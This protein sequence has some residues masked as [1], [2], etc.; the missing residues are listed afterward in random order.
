MP[1]WQFDLQQFNSNVSQ[2]PTP[3]ADELQGGYLEKAYQP[4]LVPN[5]TY[6]LACDNLEVP[7]HTGDSITR[8]K[9][10]L[11]TANEDPIDPSTATGIDNG[12]TD[13][14][15]NNEQYTVTME[16]FNGTQSI[17]IK[18][19]PMGIVDRFR[20]VVKASVKQSRQSVD[21]YR[22]NMLMGGLVVSKGTL[23]L[24]DGYAGGTTIVT[25][26][27]TTST[28]AHVDDC[29]GFDFVLV[30]GQRTAVSG[31]NK[32]PVYKNGVLIG[33]VT[34]VALDATNPITNPKT[35][36]SVGNAGSSMR[37]LQG[38][39]GGATVSASGRGAS[40]T[41]TFDTAL[42]FSIGDVIQSGYAPKIVYGG[43]K[44]HYSQLGNADLFT[45]SMIL[46][47]VAY[48][49]DAEVPTV[50]DDLYLCV[51]DNVTW[52]QL[53]AD[54][55]FKQA[56]ET[57]GNDPVY[58]NARLASHLGVAFMNSSNA[59]YTAKTGT[60][61][62]PVR[63]PMILGKGALVDGV[64]AIN[65]MF[66]DI[67][68]EEKRFAYTSETD[69]IVAAIRPPIDRQGR[70]CSVS[71]ESIRG[72]VAPTD[73]TA[74]GIVETAGSSAFKRGVVCAVRG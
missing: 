51:L 32:L 56:F 69:G 52:R 43:G 49:R 73:L 13:E 36:H 11:L 17:D 74:N 30:N 46:D 44:T 18:T 16:L 24:V 12:M 10:G 33:N 50:I 3:I 37:V 38:T 66:A 20:H 53:Y 58:R 41:L 22:R 71:W 68:D 34:G 67:S 48:L 55:D 5:E 35:G 1:R 61:A 26:N 63:W 7:A 72:A 9:P 64:S 23:T 19:S 6:H 4:G 25:A 47:A 8:T 70:Y 2:F 40:G 65:G 21:K 42:S 28:T 15:Y 59:P 27:T 45:E 54:Q 62:N 14:Q 57:R 60:M 39:T 29:S 31:T